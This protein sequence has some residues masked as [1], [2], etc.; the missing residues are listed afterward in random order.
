MK[1][2]DKNGKNQ[3]KRERERVRES[4]SNRDLKKDMKSNISR[5]TRCFKNR[6]LLLKYGDEKF[7]SAYE[8]LQVDSH[9]IFFF[10]TYELM[11]SEFVLIGNGLYCGMQGV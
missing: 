8:S 1:L 4:V 5:I 2:K 3:R 10:F 6:L 7:A 9:K 11:I